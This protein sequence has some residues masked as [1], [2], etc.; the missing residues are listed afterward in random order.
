[1]IRAALSARSLLAF[2]VLVLMSASSLAQSDAA[3]KP[4]KLV[5][6]T[7]RVPPFVLHSDDGEWSGL[8]IDLWK[9]VA[10]QLQSD[11]EFREYDYDP[12]G[13]LDAVERRQVDIAVAAIP[14]TVESESRFDFSHPYF[15]AASESRCAPSRSPACLERLPV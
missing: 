12:A 7:M 3:V 1:M 15:A 6:G 2:A 11:F 14:V 8:S 10:A 4:A 9:E 13:L 5:V